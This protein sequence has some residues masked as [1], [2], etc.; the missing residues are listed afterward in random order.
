MVVEVEV[1]RIYNLNKHEFD[2][3]KLLVFDTFLLGKNT[4]TD[5][6]FLYRTHPR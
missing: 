3:R 1:K 6:I 4:Q 2:I 5:A